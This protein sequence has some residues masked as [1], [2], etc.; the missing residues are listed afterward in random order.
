MLKKYLLEAVF[1]S[2]NT[3]IQLEFTYSSCN[4]DSVSEDWKELKTYNWKDY[5]SKLKEVEYV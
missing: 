4:W 3:D 2:F 5:E 1:M